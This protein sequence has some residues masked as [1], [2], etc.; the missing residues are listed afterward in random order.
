MFGMQDILT[1]SS[2]QSMQRK[3][4]DAD[5]SDRK[6]ADVITKTP[7]TCYFSGKL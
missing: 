6:L 4:S 3:A 1:K 2:V 5:S 7:I